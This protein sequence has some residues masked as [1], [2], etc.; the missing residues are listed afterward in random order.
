MK[1]LKL[2]NKKILLILFIF[3]ILFTY[4]THADD[5]PADIWDLEKKAEENSSEVILENIDSSE[6][7]IEIEK[8]S[9]INIIDSNE[10]KNNKINIIGLYDPEENGLK[11]DM[12]SN[13]NGEEIKSI[14]NKL[15]KIKLSSDANEILKVVLLTNTYFP[16]TN[17]TEKEF[18]N[19]KTN[20]LI[21]NRDK[22]LIK[23]Y[24]V[25]NDNNIHNSNLI[26]F[27]INSYLQN[28]DLEN[29][30]DIFNE[31]KFFDDDYINKFKI[32][33]LINE[34]KREQAQLL[35]DLNNE[36]GSKDEFYDN[37]FNFL[38]N[39]VDEQNKDISDKNILNLHLSHR[40]ISDFSYQPKNDSPD[41][42]WKYLSSSNL[43]ENIDTIDL[44][45]NEKILLIEKAT[46]EKNYDE[47]DLF[48]LYK[49]FQFN[50]NQL[51]NVKD[52][53]KLLKS[54]EG[55]ALLYQRLI[56]TED[57]IQILDLSYKLKES[58]IKDKIENAFNTELKRVLS[59]VNQEQVPSNFST[60]YSEN[61]ISEPIKKN[62]VKVNNKIIHQSRLLK[63][64]EEENEIEKIEN[65]LNKLLKSIK[66]NKDYKVSTK[67]LIL[68]E[69]LLSDGVVISKK[70]KNMFN[71][72]QSNIPTDIQLLIN[73]NELGMVLL[74]IVEII[75]EDDLESLDPD[76]LYF[77][78]TIFNKF[79][80]DS[81]RNK[82]LLKVLPLKI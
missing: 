66:K 70:Y 17:I 6:I 44:E 3:K 37:K 47:K 8:N 48:E 32:Y 79:N 25:K 63:H 81:I 24:L 9:S 42:V 56:L 45:D 22:N 12:W 38:M 68:L 55:R 82:L 73:N 75:G 49:R 33:C 36:S 5:E 72:Y 71:F 2:L 4:S 13:S 10:L 41:F 53:Y 19:F 67:D 35:F 15:N 60:F 51:L 30:C 27:Y 23:L 69:S 65:D 62:D 50:I 76:T 40:T 58:F 64:L 54:Y 39:Y 46:H 11:I 43:L 21:K 57:E 31:I 1:I 78:T 29:A 61:L 59:K 7:S 52:S 20:F 28:A 26:K 16:Q 80:L 74:R 34:N 14:L 18:I 77:L